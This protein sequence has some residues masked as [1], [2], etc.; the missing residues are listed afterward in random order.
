MR[1]FFPIEEDNNFIADI[2]IKI[3]RGYKGAI[4]SQEAGP[5]KDV[6][7][8]L[9]KYAQKRYNTWPNT[10]IK[11]YPQQADTN[12]ELSSFCAKI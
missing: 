6:K 7:L 10:F 9:P 5:L 2:T 12:N 11:S 8:S 3:P 4:L 1:V